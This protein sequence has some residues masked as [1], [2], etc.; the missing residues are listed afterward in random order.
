MP[1]TAEA[2]QPHRHQAAGR[3]G[4]FLGPHTCSV[5]TGIQVILLQE[6]SRCTGLSHHPTSLPP[7]AADAAR[8]F[9]S[10]PLSLQQKSG[11]LSSDQQDKRPSNSLTASNALTLEWRHLQSGKSEGPC[12]TIVRAARMTGDLSTDHCPPGLLERQPDTFDMDCPV[13]LQEIHR[14]PS[15]RAEPQLLRELPG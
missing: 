5:R 7:L 8:M 6:S 1:S 3:K 11:L 10:C 12:V 9:P 15:S 2:Q 4:K 14:S 13:L